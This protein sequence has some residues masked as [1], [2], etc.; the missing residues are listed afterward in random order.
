MLIFNVRYIWLK[1]DTFLIY[2]TMYMLIP[3][4]WVCWPDETK[5]RWKYRRM[6][7]IGLT[8]CVNLEDLSMSFAVRMHSWQWLFYLELE[9][10]VCYSVLYGI[11]LISSQALVYLVHKILLFSFEALLVVA[12]KFGTFLS[13][14]VL[15]YRPVLCTLKHFT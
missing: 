12:L 15:C 2:S 11:G 13:C 9:G 1:T 10:F 7:L 4:W 5:A 14:T 3:L 8:L 6:L